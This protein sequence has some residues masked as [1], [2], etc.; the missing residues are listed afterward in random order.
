MGI[1]AT[2]G[3]LLGHLVQNIH[4]HLLYRWRITTNYGLLLH[5]Q[6]V[7]KQ[8]KETEKSQEITII[9]YLY[10]PKRNFNNEIAFLV[11]VKGRN[12]IS[13]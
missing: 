6:E 9:L 2:C 11:L 8:K 7:E 12:R 13:H 5:Y 10:L 1:F 3:R 4:F